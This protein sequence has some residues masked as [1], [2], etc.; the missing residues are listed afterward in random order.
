MERDFGGE[1]SYAEW[2]PAQ[3]KAREE[4]CV[5]E[6]ERPHFG[7]VVEDE[8]PDEHQAW[9]PVEVEVTFR[10]GDGQLWPEDQFW[11][12]GY[13]NEY[14]TTAEIQRAAESL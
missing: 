12:D 5:I 4:G 9:Y 11:P 3:R 8:N 13:E 14:L 10:V 7:P 2:H 6:V 1:R